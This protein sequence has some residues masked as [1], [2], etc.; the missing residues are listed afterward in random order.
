MMRWLREVFQR[1][2]GDRGVSFVAS[3]EGQ[4]FPYDVS[5]PEELDSVI[6]ES[7][8]QAEQLLQRLDKIDS[9]R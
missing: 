9:R 8:A 5:S 2:R 1:P 3:I 6:A 7:Q 4:R